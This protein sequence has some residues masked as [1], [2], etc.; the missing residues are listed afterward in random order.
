[1]PGSTEDHQPSRR[2]LIKG[3]AGTLVLSLAPH[4]ARGATLLAVRLWPAPEYTRVTIEHDAPLQFTHFVLRDTK[5]LRMVVDI[6]GIDLSRAF[7]EQIRHIDAADPYI[8][9]MRVGQFRPEVVRLVIELK[10][11]VAPQVF[12][13][14]PA[15]PYRNRLVIDLYPES[16]SDPLLALLR[17][18]HADGAGGE[19]GAQ[20]IPD[21]QTE[22]PAPTAQAAPGKAAPPAAASKDGGAQAAANPPS[23]GAGGAQGAPGPS[24]ASPDANGASTPTDKSG[25][26]APE[27]KPLAS[28]SDTARP[29][30][31]KGGR[32]MRRLI[33][34]AIDPGHGGEDPGAIGRRGTYEKVVTLSIGRQLAALIE[35]Q[36][37][38]RVLMTRESDY[39]V[40]LAMRVEKA[41]RVQADLLVSI[42]ADAWVRSDARGSSVFALSERGATSA[43]AAELAREQNDA[44]R[45]GGVNAAGT[46]TLVSR[47]VLD[48]STTAQ[49]SDSLRVGNAVL[50]EI[51]GINRLHRGLVEQ[52]GFAVL[53]SPT[54]PSIL[55]ETAFISNPDEE[56]RLRDQGYQRQMAAAVFKGIRSYFARNPPL[57]RNPVG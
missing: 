18:Q 24:E 4:I 6:Q 27:D 10:V 55:V 49:I 57:V 3:A 8:A 20:Q 31:S 37:D 43:A 14:E 9:R 42:H 29:A 36:A 28:A 1:M 2:R 15:G 16:A 41:R 46:S 17:E 26:K 34:V 45:I 12:D 13:L 51:S 38:Y 39:F 5:P 7:V 32:A 25:A 11:P 47:V 48:L 44:D 30:R 33:T 50:R 56:A 22:E 35:E 54:I 23:P 52:A 19:G 21:A 40:P 53:K